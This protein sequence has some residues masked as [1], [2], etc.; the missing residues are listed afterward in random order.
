MSSHLDD[1]PRIPMQQTHRFLVVS[2]QIDLSDAVLRQLQTDLLERTRKLQPRGIILD[3]SG[4]TLF[5]TTEF[6]SLR[7][8]M[9]MARLMGCPSVLVGIHPGLAAAIAEMDVNCDDL[10]T[11]RSLEEAFQ[12]LAGSTA[13]VTSD[14]ESME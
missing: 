1:T 8:T 6:A 11:A 13:G 7:R 10:L 3:V 14:S 9:E 4:L 2:L 5:D 12:L